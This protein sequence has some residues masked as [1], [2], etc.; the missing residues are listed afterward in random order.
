MS[1]PR[2]RPCIHGRPPARPCFCPNLGLVKSYPCLHFDRWGRKG[3]PL[4]EH[5]RVAL[6]I[7]ALIT[8]MMGFI[9][10]M[11]AVPAAS[12]ALAADA[13]TF[14]QHSV[15]AGFALRTSTGFP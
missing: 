5:E 13:L 1:A 2:T 6:A 14:V 9:V 11:I 4:A 10:S 15:S 7:I 12:T 8:G 3:V